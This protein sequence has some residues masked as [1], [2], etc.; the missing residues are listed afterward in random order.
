MEKKYTENEIRDL[1]A[2]RIESLGMCAK[3]NME[4]A[5]ELKEKKRE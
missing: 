3:C 1:F 4:K 5:R 2:M